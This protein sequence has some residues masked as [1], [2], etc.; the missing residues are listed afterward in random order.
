[1]SAV[2]GKRGLYAPW[3]F[4]CLLVLLMAGCAPPRSPEGADAHGLA[5]GFRAALVAEATDSTAA[6]AYLDVLDAAVDHSDDPLA[7]SAILAALDALVWREVA[8]MPDYIEHA[9]VHR[10]TAALVETSRRLRR[11]WW[12]ARHI[13]LGRALIA[14]AIDDLAL[15][16]GAVREARAW[17]RRAGCAS[18]AAVA[19]PLA[20]PPLSAIDGPIPWDKEGALPAALPGVRPFGGKVGFEVVYADACNFGMTDTG[21]H[22]GMRAVVVDIDNPEA[23]KLYLAVQTGSAARVELGGRPLLARAYAASATASLHLAEAEVEAGLARLVILLAHQRYDEGVA[24]QVVDASGEPL[25]MHAPRAGDVAKAR[26][27][28]ARALGWPRARDADGLA[29]GVAAALARG[30]AR[31]AAAL[32]SASGRSSSP[33]LDLLR[34]R[35]VSAAQLVPPSQLLPEVEAGAE[36]ILER[37]PRCWEASLAAAAASAERRGIATGGFAKLSRLAIAPEESAFAGVDP[38]LLSFVADGAHQVELGALARRAYDALA[39]RSPG[40]L[41][42]ADLDRVLYQRQGEE[43]VRAACAGGMRRSTTQCLQ[44]HAE[45]SD[46]RAVQHELAWLRALRGSPALLRELEI[47]LLLAHGAVDEALRIYDALPPARRRLAWLGAATGTPGEKASRER[48][49]RDMAQAEDAPGG[50]E[51][52]VRLFG[53]TGDPSAELERQ[54]AELAARDRREAYLPGAATA[55]LRHRERYQLR[56]DGLLAFW[57]YDLRRVSG[58]SDV[59]EGTEVGAPVIDGRS[60]TRV[61]RRRIHKRDGRVIDPDPSAD[62]AQG[63]TDLSQLEAGDH[64]ELFVVGWALPGDHGQLV[65]DTPDVLPPRTS[66]REGSIELVSPSGLNLAVWAHQLLG[67]PREQRRGESRVR[68]WRLENRP[69]RRIEEGVPPLE[70][71]V[72]ISFGSDSYARIA[73]GLGERFR[74]LDDLDPYMRRWAT[75]AAGSTKLPTDKRVARI[76]AAAGKAIPRADPFMLSDESTA[77]L[78]GT[79]RETA[80]WFL[81][82]GAGS[83]SWVV[84][85]ALREI[86]V[87]SEVAVAETRPFS[88]AA[89]FPP[90]VGRFSHPLVRAT[91]DGKPLWIDADVEGPPLPPGRISPE[92]RG[93]SALLPN[94]RIVAVEAGAGDDADVIDLRLVLDARGDARGTLSAL[95]HGRPAQQLAAAF[96]RVVGPERTEL[97]HNVVLGWVPSADVSQ[98]RLSSEEGSWQVAVRADITVVGLARPEG[99]SGKSFSLAGVEPY[100]EVYPR[101]LAISLGARYAAQADRSEALSIDEP[102]LFRVRRRIELPKG[103]RVTHLAPPF[104]LQVTQLSAARKVAQEGQVLV[105]EFELN[106]PV[107]TVAGDEFEAF[108]DAVQRTDDAFSYSTRLELE[109]R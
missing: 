78:G 94:G 12:R 22:P 49:R 21:P 5:A 25:R 109:G 100:H 23:Q 97:L 86:G 16:V 84:H 90:R 68:E 19:G 52:L 1:V 92:L 64:V 57:I 108:L 95:L 39:K 65:V 36:H 102:L 80:R 7:L 10:S 87:V 98:V 47:D 56:G 55:V 20:W 51:P 69:P 42:L 4:G 59:A 75:S 63:A 8:A 106:L 70:A 103:A 46:L 15:R 60:N 9:I 17:R 101:A 48:L 2:A 107:G 3:A 41:M 44:A 67:A 71:R 62:G 14:S 91:I 88:A 72:A 104:T 34:L 28:K 89:G 18:T 40:S 96:E 11:A 85:R 29:L 73:A 24:I 35:A 79:H 13:P 66:I 58:T 77:F 30:E 37:C 26:V 27:A 6:A 54:G 99:R 33:Y 105:E 81:E 74:A 76:V 31:H 50:L 53:V 32:L 61:L 83:R 43:R 82:Q 45:R 38:M 93:R